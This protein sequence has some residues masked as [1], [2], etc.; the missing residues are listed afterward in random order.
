M[1]D[2]EVPADGVDGE[3]ARPVGEQPATA[4]GEGDE[5]IGVGP[6]GTIGEELHGG[7]GDHSGGVA[8]RGEQG[9]DTVGFVAGGD[10][11]DG[12]LEQRWAGNAVPV[13]PAVLDDPGGDEL[14]EPV[15]DERREQGDE[16]FV[17]RWRAGFVEVD[18]L[19]RFESEDLTEVGA[20]APGADEVADA[21]EGV[22]AI[23]EP[24]DER[25]PIDVRRPVDADPSAS[26]GAGEQADGLVLADRPHREAR[27][28]GE[29][30]DRE[31][32]PVIGPDRRRLGG[33]SIHL[34]TV[35]PSTVT[36]NTVNDLPVAAASSLEERLLAVLRSATS[37]PTLT[38]D[39]PPKRLTGG[40]WAELVAFRLRGA[41][42][43][44]RGDLVARVMPDAAVAAKETVFQAEVAAQGFPTPAVHLAGGAEAGLGRAFMV[45]DL[46][47]GV[48]M[49]DGLGGV[50]AI[51]A[52]PRLARRL[53][54]TL[55]DTM[56]SLHRL[57]P[58]PVRTRLAAAGGGGLGMAGLLSGLE[59]SAA[60]HDRADL[61]A[62]ARWL[63]QHPPEEAPEVIC[64][65]DL[66]PFNLLVTADGAVTVLDWSVG[67]LA[68][69]AFDVAFT[70]LMLAEPPVAMPR[71]LRPVVRAVG[72][73]LARRFRRAYARAAAA[74]DPDSL[75]W[76]EAVVCLRA[77]GEV[78]GWVAAGSVDEHHGH[79]WLVCGPAFAARLSRLTGVA[80]T[81]R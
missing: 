75:R 24:T 18:E 44:W 66:H 72:R 13:R 53:P 61:V 26:F 78:A 33:Q 27:V 50:E 57:D 35:T 16:L 52:L 3:P 58:A 30:V 12:E 4:G 17:G 69:A 39:G 36:V 80:V 37:T 79:P 40:F 11:V 5:L 32:E 34:S 23:L 20:V 76:H 1:T 68:P 25:Q 29:L 2:A 43:A 41:P 60:S 64:H 38:F 10:G 77:L 31:L 47:I 9:E 62:A 67:V 70:G 59:A 63:S 21:G 15:G 71:P 65:G 14:V 51:A 73:L 81:P 8:D 6:G 28:G 42:T 56:A 55:A 49:L 46:A 48:P 74:M 54:A 45:M 7:H 19:V 22:A